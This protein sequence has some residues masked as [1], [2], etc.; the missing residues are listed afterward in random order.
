MLFTFMAGFN[1]LS[2]QSRSDSIVVISE[3]SNCYPCIDSSVRFK[4]SSKI[5]NASYDTIWFL[6]KICDYSSMFIFDN[7][8]LKIIDDLPC[9]IIYPQ[10]VCLPPGYC[11][12]RYLDFYNVSND[13]SMCRFKIGFRTKI[14]HEKPDESTVYQVFLQENSYVVV[15]S[16]Y[17]SI[18]A[19]NQN[20]IYKR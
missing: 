7:N 13:C 16:N 17:M 18:L 10:F 5:I 3:I 8:S 19:L 15:W 4:I 2:A 11:T 12:N 14:F 6:D 1:V 20:Y 9:Y